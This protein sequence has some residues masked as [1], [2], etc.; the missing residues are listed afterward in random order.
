MENTTVF[1]PAIWNWIVI[2]F[3]I[4][5]ARIFDVT[6]GTLRI[7]LV[8][9]GVKLF[10]PMLGFFEVLIWLLAIGQIMQNLDNPINYFAYALGFAAGTYAGIVTENKIAMGVA[11][12]RVITIKEASKLVE[13]LREE[14][15]MITVIDAE[16]NRGPVKVF[17]TI[18][19]RKELK[20]IVK[21]IKQFNPNAFYTIEDINFVNQVMIPTKKHTRR[22]LKLHGLKRK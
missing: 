7:I 17:F 16:G 11:L 8:S 20:S 18:D 10:A 21:T 14:G 15:R 22:L 13:H 6:I 4:F 9:K 1:S 2:P 19:K 5:V 3:L 12:I